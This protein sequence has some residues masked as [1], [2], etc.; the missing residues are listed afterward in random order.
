MNVDYGWREALFELICSFFIC[1]IRVEGYLY[2]NSVDAVPS[3][4][5]IG[6][7][8]D[9]IIDSVMGR[10]QEP[11]IKRDIKVEDDDEKIEIVHHIP[12]P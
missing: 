12:G 6:R 9:N 7:N 3:L 1:I 4:E 5:N 8:L 11:L 2:L 10:L